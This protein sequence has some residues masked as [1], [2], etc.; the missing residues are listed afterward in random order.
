VQEV[1]GGDNKLVFQYGKGGG[2]GFGTLARFYYPDF[3][4]Y[5][6]ASESRLRVLDVLTI[7]PTDYLGAQMNVVYQRDDMGTG[8]D[9]AVKEWYSAGTRLSFA[10]TEH[11]KLLGEVG[12]DRVKKSNGADPQWLAKFTIAPTIA[13]ARG[14]WGRP[15]LRLFYTWATWSQAAATATVDS[16]QVYTNPDPNTG[17]YKLSG[18]IIGLQAEAM[19]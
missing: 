14:F 5:H 2:T 19:W 7:Q 17:A 12:Y 9:G 16:G 10:F 4:I 15:E 1:L 18:S 8:V 13:G 11:A 6:G 3:S